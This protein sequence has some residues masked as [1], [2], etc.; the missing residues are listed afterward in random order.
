M[1]APPIPFTGSALDSGPAR[2]VAI[3]IVRNIVGTA[4]GGSSGTFNPATGAIETT[5][6]SLTTTIIADAV[7]EENHD[8]ESI[9]TAQPVEVGSVI[10]DH[11]YR[12]PSRLELLYAW[13]LG[14]QQNTGQDLSFLK[15]LYATALSL[16]DNAVLCTVNTG[17]RVY[18]NMVVKQI[19]ERT[20]KENENSMTLRLVL[21]EIILVTSQVVNIAP[22]AQQALPEQT[23]GIVNAGS[24]NLQPAPNFNSAG[25]P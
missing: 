21:Q 1:S 18:E 6:T 17:K 25:G 22:Q 23:S 7:I 3:T 9:V 15:N 8:D 24:L 19:I 20:D 11:M 14:S 4:P 16:K 10:N 12:L 5:A 13:A 2:P